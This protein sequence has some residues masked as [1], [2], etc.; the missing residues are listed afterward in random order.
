M[1][2]GEPVGPPVAA[3]DTA[4]EDLWR[5]LVRLLVLLPRRMDQDLVAHTG[6]SL[7]RY[8]V[9]MRLSET[10]GATLRM[11][12]LA[13]AASISPSRMTR[14]AQSLVEDGLLTRRSDP[15]DAR[16]QLATLTDAGRDSLERARPAHLASVRALVI[17]HVAP[18][19]RE[20]IT[21]VF[22]QLLSAVEPPARQ[23]TDPPCSTTESDTA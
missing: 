6:L 9:L 10:E 8:V 1:S 20:V 4:E 3:L 5:A 13:D 19:D 23:P 18:A 7:T 22:R 21:R 15:C 11:G 2:R 12:D 16:T 17:D 14:L